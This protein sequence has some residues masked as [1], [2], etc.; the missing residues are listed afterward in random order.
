VV[1]GEWSVVSCE[2]EV[3]GFQSTALVPGF[4]LIC[5][6]KCTFHGRYLMASISELKIYLKEIDEVIE[7]Y[8]P[9][10]PKPEQVVGEIIDCRAKQ[11]PILTKAIELATQGLE[12]FEFHPA[13]LRR[14][15]FVRSFMMNEEREY[16]ELKGAEDD[17][18]AILE[19]DSDHI[20][21]GQDLLEIMFTYNEMEDSKVA[22]VAAEFAQRA[23][24]ILLALRALQIKAL[25]YADKHQEA[26][27][28][29]EQWSRLFPDSEVLR[30]AKKEADELKPSQ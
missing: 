22:E 12:I 18:Q 24:K 7:R 10:E 1:S 30:N 2:K 13:L 15:A 21:A 6:T 27:T 26:Q 8:D 3:D 4:I 17:L 25:A 29:Y 5:N 28:L 20:G 19:Y 11:R 23:Q 16:P 9:G 14:R